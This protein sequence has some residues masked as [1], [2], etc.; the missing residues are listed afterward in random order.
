[1]KDLGYTGLDDAELVARFDSLP[2]QN[3]KAFAQQI[4][5]TELKE[6]GLD[7]TDPDSP[8]FQ[9]YKRG[10]DAIKQLFPLDTEH[11]AEEERANK[12]LS[13]RRTEERRVGKRGVRKCKERGREYK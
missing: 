7:V 2:L 8:R 13:A 11:I 4:F 10:F 1:M 6:T 5:F 3:H 12:I 9:N